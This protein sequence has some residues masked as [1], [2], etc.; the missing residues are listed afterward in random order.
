MKLVHL[1]S[2]HRRGLAAVLAG[3]AVFASLSAVTGR[4][5]PDAVTVVVAARLVPAGSTVTEADVRLAR[6]PRTAVPDGVL[7][8][9]QDA[10]G[11]VTGTGIRSGQMLTDLSL[12]GGAA[13]DGTVVLSVRLDNPELAALAPPGSRVTL[14]A[15][16]SAKAVVTHVLVVAAPDVGGGGILSGSSTSVLLVRVTPEEA[17][18]ITAAMA[19][20]TLT[21]AIG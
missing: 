21:L 12:V 15:T 20:S 2:W 9:V 4:E 18:A 14:Y 17:G 7:T 16:T 11:K 19:A 1:I 6:M 5:E 10:M 8:R 13:Q 3:V